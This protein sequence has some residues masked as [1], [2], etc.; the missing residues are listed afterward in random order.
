MKKIPKNRIADLSRLLG[1]R[2]E[3]VK[4]MVRVERLP[5]PD[6]KDWIDGKEEWFWHDYTLIEWYRARKIPDE[7]LLRMPKKAARYYHHVRQ[8]QI[9]DPRTFKPIFS[10]QQ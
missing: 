5:Q 10:K 7:E 8:T 9:F 6:H 2:P 4:W 1:Y 3:T